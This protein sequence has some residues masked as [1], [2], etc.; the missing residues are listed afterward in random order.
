MM[1]SSSNAVLITGGARRVGRAIALAFAARG[2]DV[3]LHFRRSAEEAEITRQEILSI[4]VACECFAADLQDSGARQAMLQRVFDTFPH[5]RVLVNNASIFERARFMETDEV[6]FDRQMDINFRVPFFLTQEFIKHCPEARVINMLDTN[7]TAT[8]TSHFSYLLAKKA[9]AEFTRMAARELAPKARIHGVCP[10]LVIPAEGEEDESYTEKYI[11]QSP[12]QS[13][14][15]P[16]DVAEAVCWLAEAE[17]V[18]GQLLF[19]DGG[20]HLL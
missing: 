12:L 15:P 4:G 13:I 2:Y 11:A 7:I 16:E 8:Q 17:S 20:K 19:L 10:G 6:L 9:L 1:S 5:C 18:T 14:S 3:A